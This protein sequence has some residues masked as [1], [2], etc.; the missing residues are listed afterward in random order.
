MIVNATA[1]ADCNPR[2]PA[3]K[4]GRKP[5]LS[6]AGKGAEV[7]VKVTVT[8]DRSTESS[9]A[10]WRASSASSSA[11][12]RAISVSSARMSVIVVAWSSRL[13]NVSMTRYAEVTRLSTS[14]TSAVT[15]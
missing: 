1:V 5:R 3:S 4:P 14:A 10:R 12:R 15:S 13:R 8:V 6:S 7:A 9:R 2:Q 11:S